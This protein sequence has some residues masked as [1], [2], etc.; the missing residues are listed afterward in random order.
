MS[1]IKN[2]MEMSFLSIS[3]MYPDEYILVKIIE[4]NHEN[5]NTLGIAIYTASSQDDLDEYAIK[6]GLIND[7]IVLQ[8]E[9]LFPVMGGII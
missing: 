2:A 1:K 4:I 9:N 6:E 3:E 5:G 8:G 7:T